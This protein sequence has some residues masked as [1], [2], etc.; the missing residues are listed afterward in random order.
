M[1]RLDGMAGG[2]AKGEQ[3]EDGLDKGNHLLTHH[4]LCTVLIHSW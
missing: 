2:G 3:N 1:G 4:S